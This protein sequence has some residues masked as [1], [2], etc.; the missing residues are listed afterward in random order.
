[1]SNV[2]S[3]TRQPAEGSS[4]TAAEL[5]FREACSD[6]SGAILHRDPATTVAEPERHFDLPLG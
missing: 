4:C 3:V 1:M 6:V 2:R 5:P